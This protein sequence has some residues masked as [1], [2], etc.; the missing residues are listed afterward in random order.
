M[1][2]RGLGTLT[3]LGLEEHVQIILNFFENHQFHVFYCVTLVY[4]LFRRISD[5]QF[6]WIHDFKE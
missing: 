5:P 1:Q 2:V 6:T 4:V 3:A